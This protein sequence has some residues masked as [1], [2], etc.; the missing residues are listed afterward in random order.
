L[1]PLVVD[2]RDRHAD[3]DVLDDVGHLRGRATTGT[4]TEQRL[5]LLLGAGGH[6]AESGGDWVLAFGELLRTLRGRGRRTAAFAR[7]A[8]LLLE[9]LH[10][11]GGTRDREVLH[12][13]K[14]TLR[15]GVVLDHLA[16]RAG[17]SA[18]GLAVGHDL[19]SII[20]PGL[21][22]P[23]E[24]NVQRAPGGSPPDRVRS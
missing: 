21:P 24:R 18:C 7:R 12:F 14:Q 2:D 20:R 17:D 1:R 11:A 6:G 3:V 19:A 4:P 5:A 23:P 10:P 13:V 8:E 16:E 9:R 15:R 22:T